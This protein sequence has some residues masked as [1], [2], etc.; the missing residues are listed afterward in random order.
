M[1]RPYVRGIKLSDLL[2]ALVKA[3]LDRLVLSMEDSETI[4]PGPR[5]LPTSLA[6]MDSQGTAAP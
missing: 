3:G 1:L 6:E 2:S 4:P 5:R